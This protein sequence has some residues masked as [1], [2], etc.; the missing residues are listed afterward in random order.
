[1]H[2]CDWKVTHPVCSSYHARACTAVPVKSRTLPAPHHAPR[3][4]IAVTRK[5]RVCLRIIARTC[6]YSCD[7]K[8]TRPACS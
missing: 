5:A 2:S 3:A 4:C 1:M 6:M 7:W 8:D